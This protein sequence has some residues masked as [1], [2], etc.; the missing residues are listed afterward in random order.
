MVDLFCGCGGLSLG[1][2]EACRQHKVTVEIAFAVDTDKDA[3]Q[4][5]RR[6]IGSICAR[7]ECAGIEELFRGTL[8]ARLSERERKLANEVGQIDLLVAGPPCQGHSDLNNHSRRLDRRNALYVRVARATDVLRPS[9]VIIENVIGVVNDRGR[10]LS[11]TQ[12]LLVSRGYAVELIR[13][14]A[15][16][17]GA[18][19]NRRRHFLVAF[20]ESSKP[21]WTPLPTH[22]GDSWTV[23]DV[24][25]GLEDEPVSSK[26]T[27]G[28]PSK[29]TET[30]QRRIEFLFNAGIYNLPDSRRPPCHKNNEH[31]YRAVYGRLRW[32]GTAN[33]ITSGFGSM[34]QGRYV[35]PTR[36][37]VITPHEAARL[38]G[39]PDWFRFDHVD[40]R[41]SLQMMIGNAVVPRVAAWLVRHLLKSGI[42]KAR[43][44]LAESSRERPRRAGKRYRV[45]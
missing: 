38:Q 33:T 22:H 20:A 32:D 27:F 13:I 6:N 8:N 36:R 18:A 14:D 34:G 40:S 17:V 39:F 45:A 26:S 4:V 30:N 21:R 2:V 23:G 35:H 42:L 25:A 16:A 44:T 43:P 3:L 37:R 19:Q 7:A 41:G 1:I 9:V 28:T 24:L 12:S 11:R 15:S 10:A 31:S 5:Y 29:C